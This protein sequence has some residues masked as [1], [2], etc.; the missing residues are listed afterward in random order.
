MGWQLK[1][2]G[3]P[4]PETP[5]IEL[6][7]AVD[8]VPRIRVEP[9]APGQVDRVDIYYAIDAPWAIGRFWR[10]AE[11]RGK[12]GRFHV[13]AAPFL[14]EG[15]RLHAFANVSYRSGLQL[16][17][18]VVE[19][20]TSAIPGAAP[21]LRH[22]ALIDDMADAG[23][24]YWVPAYPDPKLDGVYFGPW[25]GP[26]GERGFTVVPFESENPPF[27][28]KDGTLEFCMG[29]HKMGDPQWRGGPGEEA[30]LI[31]VYG[32]RA[33]RDLKVRVVAGF[34]Q[35]GQR[36][37][38]LSVEIPRDAKGWVELRWAASS[39][40]DKDGKP[41]EGWSG[42][43]FLQLSGVSDIERPPVFRNLRWSGAP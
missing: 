43:Q 40:K 27:V 20:E 8:G 34:Y 32:P 21:T 26:G 38:S 9:D 41:L 1:G 22:E 11:S 2:E 35:R 14:H 23:D 12:E 33:P 42:V 39:F 31:D 6:A 3:G 28:R 16:S 37:Y 4:W 13:G 10:D 7:A 25:A 19:V 36:E 17:T 24:W 5:R 15:D 29:T 18:R 30:L